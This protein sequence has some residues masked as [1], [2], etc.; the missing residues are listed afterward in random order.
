[1]KENKLY[2]CFKSKYILFRFQWFNKNI[3]QATPMFFFNVD[4]CAIINGMKWNA[5]ALGHFFFEGLNW[6][7]TAWANEVNF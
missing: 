2:K 7:G 4:I 6:A 1:M 5:V 3:V